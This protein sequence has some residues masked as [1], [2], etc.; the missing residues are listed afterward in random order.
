[1]RRLGL[2]SSASTY[3]RRTPSR[4]QTRR[5]RRRCRGCCLCMRVDERWPRRRS[6]PVYKQEVSQR[7]VSES[8]PA[9][10]TT[11]RFSTE[12]VVRALEATTVPTG[13]LADIR[14]PARTQL[15]SDICDFS[16]EPGV[17]WRATYPRRSVVNDP[18][19]RPV[20][21]LKLVAPGK[22]IAWMDVPCGTF[23]LF[24][25]IA[26]SL[27]VRRAKH[28]CKG[29]STNGDRGRHAA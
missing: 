23:S 4:A 11:D 14:C 20:P 16:G 1:M 8:T 25:L 6:Q 15:D 7:P 10:S 17:L 21:E 19:C 26:P 13:Y 24:D 5:R 12:R 9:G 22:L 27:L 18:T 3:N 29:D 28:D 2:A